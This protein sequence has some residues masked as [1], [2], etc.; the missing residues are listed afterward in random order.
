MII[1]RT[2]DELN[3]AREALGPVGFVPTMGALHEGHLSLVRRAQAECDRVIVTIFVNPTQFGPNE[4][5]G[6]YPRREAEDLAKLAAGGVSLVWLPEAHE[7][8]PEGFSTSVQ[9]QDITD[10]LCGPHRPGHFQGVAT[11]V[12]KLLNQT[13]ADR[14]YFGEKDYQQ[15][16]VIKRL[17]RDLDLAVEIVGVATVR[18]SDGL[19]LSSRNAYLSAEERCQAAA[20]PIILRETAQA[21][22]AGA[23]S[24][25][26][27]IDRAIE[28]LLESGFRAI[29]YLAICDAET[30]QPAHDL[31]RPARVFVAARLGRTR[32]IDN[33]PIPVDV[34]VQ[35]PGSASPAPT[36]R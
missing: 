36:D 18:E 5:F 34:E 3:A 25:V 30:L 31:A 4:D 7:M 10:G 27:L 2:L 17:A 20:L 8:Y 33:M 14:A 12:T 1:A 29:D 24:F 15:L 16:Q 19:A 6:A 11:V 23:T 35:M 26:T 32:L 9:V 22:A 13:Q 21:A 28:R